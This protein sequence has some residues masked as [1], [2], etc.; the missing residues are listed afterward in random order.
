MLTEGSN[1]KNDILV[2]SR[3]DGRSQYLN[4]SFTEFDR[5]GDLELTCLERDTY[6]TCVAV[7]PQ[8][9][10]VTNCCHSV[11]HERAGHTRA[12]LNRISSEQVIRYPTWFPKTPPHISADWKG[13]ARARFAPRMS[14]G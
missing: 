8:V 10:Y 9:Q 4:A 12:S 14:K 3:L 7:S 5:P 1:E 2:V 6:V 11:S 13:V